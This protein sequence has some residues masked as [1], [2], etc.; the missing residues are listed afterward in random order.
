MIYV[1][2]AEFYMKGWD[3]IIHKKAIA[4][5]TQNVKTINIRLFGNAPY[6]LMIIFPN[7]E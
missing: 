3:V 7:I 6:R 2:I 1:Q 5:T 4:I